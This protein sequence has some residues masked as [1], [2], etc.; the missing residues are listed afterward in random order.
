MKTMTISIWAIGMVAVLGLALYLFCGKHSAIS[1]PDDNAV[2]QDIIDSAV[3]KKLYGR[4]NHYNDV[5]IWSS[6]N[7]SMKHW[8]PILAGEQAKIDE[9]RE[10]IKGLGDKRVSASY[11]GWLDYYQLN[12]DEAWKELRTQNKKKEMDLFRANWAK[13]R[14]AVKRFSDENPIPE[15]PRKD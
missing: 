11:S 10:W 15:P 9:I 4:I 12:L 1:M 14:E 3:L 7:Y 8:G 13:E 6:K 2:S 5:S